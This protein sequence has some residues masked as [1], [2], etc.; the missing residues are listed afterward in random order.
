MAKLSVLGAPTQSGTYRRGCIMGPAALRTAGL[1]EAFEALGHQVTSDRD[2][3]AEPVQIDD[4][5]HAPA[6]HVGETAGWVRG[7]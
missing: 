3:V 7:R 6:H 4:A 2:L 1:V 5:D